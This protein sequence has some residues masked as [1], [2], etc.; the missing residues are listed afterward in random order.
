MG[1]SVTDILPRRSG[2]PPTQECVKR[3]I[4]PGSLDGPDRASAVSNASY[5]VTRRL[6]TKR[7]RGNGSLSI[8]WDLSVNSNKH[9]GAPMRCP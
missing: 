2:W 1:F 4:T 8:A 5:S 7:N 6:N 3:V 9:T